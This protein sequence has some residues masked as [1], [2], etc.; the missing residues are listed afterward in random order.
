MGFSYFISGLSKLTIDAW[1]SG[2]AIFW[3]LSSIIGRRNIFADLL[4][5]NV[6]II[7]LMTWMTVA[8]E[9]MAPVALY[10]DK[11]RS[12]WWYLIFAMHFYLMIS[13]RITEASILILAF[14]IL[15]F[16]PIWENGPKKFNQPV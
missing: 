2:D 11:L 3:V 12:K 4:L 6:W 14:H 10:F 7:K 1:Q 9:L 15:V 16:P 8:L 13:T 5:A